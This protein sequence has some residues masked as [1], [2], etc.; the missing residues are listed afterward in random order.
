MPLLASLA[1]I[2]SDTASPSLLVWSSGVVMVIGLLMVQLKVCSARVGAVVG[3]D[4][5]AVRAI[6]RRARG[7]R[8]G[9]GARARVDLQ[10]RRQTQRRVDERAAAAVA[11]ADG[12]RNGV[13]FVVGL[14]GG[15]GDA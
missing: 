4:G 11:G 12:Q 5:D 9:D 7:H 10:P 1:L 6:G 14:V 2:V 13:A 3:H 15:S 8:A